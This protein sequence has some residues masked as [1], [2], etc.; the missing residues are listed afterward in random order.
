MI[1]PTLMGW[2]LSPKKSETIIF[3]QDDRIVVLAES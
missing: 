1:K 2:Y 3:S